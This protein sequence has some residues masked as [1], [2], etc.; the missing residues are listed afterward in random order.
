MA[1]RRRGVERVESVHWDEELVLAHAMW[2]IKRNNMG[3]FIV[4]S[5]KNGSC[6]FDRENAKIAENL[7]RV[8][9][10]NRPATLRRYGEPDYCTDDVIWAG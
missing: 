5:D 2:V 10:G 4:A 7:H 3:P 6:L 1:P 9:E 8:Y